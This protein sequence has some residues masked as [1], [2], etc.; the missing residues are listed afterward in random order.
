MQLD[1]DYRGFSF[2]KEGPLDMR[3]DPT[4]EL[5]AQVIVNTWSEDQLAE[6]IREYGEEPRWRRAAKA[7]V[8]AR[9]KKPLRTTQELSNVILEELKSKT[10]GRLHPAT[11]VFQALRMCVNREIDSLSEGLT[12]AIKRTNVGGRIGVMSFH[13]LEDRIVKNIFKAY[14]IF[15]SKKQKEDAAGFLKIVTKKPLVPSLAEIRRNP[16]SRSAKLRFAERA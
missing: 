16:R 15:P 13:R 11:L 1:L 4:E 10:R 5:T 8:A 3:M 12:N 14:S 7:I 9:R 2:S 6:I